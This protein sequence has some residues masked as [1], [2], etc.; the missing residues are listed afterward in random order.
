MKHPPREPGDGEGSSDEEDERPAKKLGKLRHLSNV[1]GKDI[2]VPKKSSGELS[3][4]EDYLTVAI[5]GLDDDFASKENLTD[6]KEVPLAKRLPKGLHMMEKMG[7][8]AE[9]S[10]DLSSQ[11][12]R[13]IIPVHV[14]RD[15][16]GIRVSP[17]LTQ[18]RG[19]ADSDDYRKRIKDEKNTERKEGI[20]LGMQKLA[21]TM[22][23]EID[24]FNS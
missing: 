19:S 5:E 22:T 10:L 24:S 1:G 17:F 15:R 4:P 2:H 23:E 14:K 6:I 9:Q 7:Y 12:D 8:T 21:F 13:G 20:L 3:E 16:L 11:G 18:T